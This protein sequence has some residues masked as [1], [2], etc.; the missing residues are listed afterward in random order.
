[1]YNITKEQY[2]IAED[3]GVKIFPS[4]NPKYKLDIYDW[5]GIYI[6]SCG[7][8]NYNDYFIYKK[9]DKKLAEQRR[10]LYYLRHHKDISKLGSRGY[11]SA[12]LLWNL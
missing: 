2:E 9:K 12:K 10:N 11:Y 8:K 7:A 5:N 1:M 3:L 4:D 6:L